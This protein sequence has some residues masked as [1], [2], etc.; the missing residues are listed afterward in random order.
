MYEPDPAHFRRRA[1]S[2]RHSAGHPAGS[3]PV[4]D[5][6]KHRFSPCCSPYPLT[7]DTLVHMIRCGA[8]QLHVQ[9]MGIDHVMMIQMLVAMDT[10]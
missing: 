10:C 1:G 6:V 8:T 7:V 5:T 2:R 3:D 4:S 9:M